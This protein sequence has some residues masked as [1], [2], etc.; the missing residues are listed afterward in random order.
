MKGRKLTLAEK[1]K[2]EIDKQL[3]KIN[4]EKIITRLMKE[5]EKQFCLED[6]Y[7]KCFEEPMT[8]YMINLDELNFR[9]NHTNI[10]NKL[11]NEGYDTFIYGINPELEKLILDEYKKL[12]FKNLQAGHSLFIKSRE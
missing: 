4:E 5:L 1:R 6:Y 2:K 9:I 12:G 11:N 8:G 7:I 10:I 3:S